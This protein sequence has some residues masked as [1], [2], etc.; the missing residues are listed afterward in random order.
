MMPP[1]NSIRLKNGLRRSQFQVIDGGG[2]MVMLEK[3]RE[4]AHAVEKFLGSL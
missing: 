2:H 3:S 4:V 1:E